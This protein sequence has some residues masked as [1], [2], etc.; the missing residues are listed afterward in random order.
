MGLLFLC[1]YLNVSWQNNFICDRYYYF[2]LC[3][4]ILYLSQLLGHKL[5]KEKSIAHMCMY[6]GVTGHAEHV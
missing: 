6:V 5:I 3:S 4:L 1:V 2:L